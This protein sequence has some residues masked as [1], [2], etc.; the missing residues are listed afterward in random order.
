MGNPRLYQGKNT[1]ICSLRARVPIDSEIRSFAP[2]SEF[3]TKTLRIYSEMRSIKAMA[4]ILLFKLVKK[5][6]RDLIYDRM[7]IVWRNL[8]PTSFLVQKS[9]V[10]NFSESYI[11]YILSGPAWGCFSH[12]PGLPTWAWIRRFRTPWGQIYGLYQGLLNACSW[13]NSTQAFLNTQ[14]CYPIYRLKS[15]NEWMNSVWELSSGRVGTDDNDV[16]EMVTGQ[17]GSNDL[18][19]TQKQIVSLLQNL[20]SSTFP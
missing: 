11:R 3:F 13:N 8:S 14:S 5:L 4:L 6:L 2:N 19:K 16:G 7:K 12:G 9:Y 15:I 1:N 20:I 17:L 10:E 18:H